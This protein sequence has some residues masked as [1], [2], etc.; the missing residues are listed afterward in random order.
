MD[1]LRLAWPGDGPEALLRH[2][3]A[4]LLAHSPCG[5]LGDDAAMVAIERIGGGA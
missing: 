3:C 5:S 4:D 1:P 2:L